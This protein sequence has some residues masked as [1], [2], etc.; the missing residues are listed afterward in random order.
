MK[1]ESPAFRFLQSVCIESSLASLDSDVAFLRRLAPL[2]IHHA[3]CQH[4]LVQLYA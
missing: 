2:Q 1:R 3:A 4:F